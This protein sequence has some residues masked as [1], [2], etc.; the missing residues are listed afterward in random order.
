M[1]PRRKRQGEHVVFIRVGRLKFYDTTLDSEGPVGGGSFNDDDVGSEIENFRA[2]CGMLYGYAQVSKKGRGYNPRRVGIEPNDEG[3]MPGVLVVM[4]AVAE[5]GRGQVV[6]GWYR[7]ATVFDDSYD[8]PGDRY[9]LF[10]FWARAQ[11]AVLL[12]I[13]RRRWPAHK[14]AGGFGQANVF[15]LRDARGRPLDVPWARRVLKKIR[16]Y[17][18]PN[19]LRG[20]DTTEVESPSSGGRGPRLTAAENRVV[21]Q[22]AMRKATAYF[23]ARRYRVR[24]VHRDECYDLLC[25]R[26]GEDD[27]RVEVKGTTGSGDKVTVTAN[28]VES[29]LNHRTALFVVS[30]IKLRRGGGA[31]GRISAVGGQHNCFL[32]WRPRTSDLRA[33]Q[34]ECRTPRKPR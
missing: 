29:A 20:E 4:V 5:A 23:A 12:P 11:D 21:E 3:E 22:A 18:G 14:G 25:E 34:Y 28:E 13:A 31:N 17:R 2:F 15:Y 33:T 10:N 8:R 7:D 26:T 9:G 1:A 30:G 32:P 24:D 16:E 19:L 6:V 27:L